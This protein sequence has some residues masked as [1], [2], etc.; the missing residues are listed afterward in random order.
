VKNKNMVALLQQTKKRHPRL[1][2]FGTLLIVFFIFYFLNLSIES[3]IFGM[4]LTSFMM[5]KL[6]AKNLAVAALASLSFSPLFLILDDEYLAEIAAMASFTLILIIFLIK[7]RVFYQNKKNKNDPRIPPR[8][9]LENINLQTL[10]LILLIGISLLF[11]QKIFLHGGQIE[12][13]DL[14]LPL[15]SQKI[16]GGLKFLWNDYESAAVNMTTNM[17]PFN[18][19]NDAV[20]YLF[21]FS[22]NIATK[23]VIAE[24]LF[25]CLFSLY[26]LLKKIFS[27]FTKNRQ[28][29]ELAS[30]A[31][32]IF[33]LFNPYSLNRIYHL[34]HWIAYL[35]L[36]L[37][38]LIFLKLLETNKAR[39]AL[40]LAILMNLISFSPHYLVYSFYALSIF[41][42][43]EIIFKFRT[44]TG[45]N[46]LRLLGRNF[47]SLLLAALLFFTLASYWLLPYLKASLI[48]DRPQAPAYMFTKRYIEA[49]EEKFQNIIS[50]LSLEPIKTE[51]RILNLL[52][53][54]ITFLL[55]LL[56]TLP[57]FSRNCRNQYTIYF[58][59]L[60]AG[61]AIFSTMPIW[62]YILYQKII[63]DL[64]Y[65]KNFG[66]LFRE[67]NRINGLLAFAY[68][69]LLSFLI[70]TRLPHFISNKTKNED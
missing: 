8:F 51:S 16:L 3:M 47:L 60:G 44:Q 61:A 4:A 63:F 23:F 67:A 17:F 24:T 21:H 28:A 43:L 50:I 12:V 5:I 42:F 14:S 38:F 36:P 55:P 57:Y 22:A 26:F 18:L 19:C 69:F 41:Y 20:F 6:P 35:T 56:L 40:A 53:Q 11:L 52:F 58:A 2:Y 9:I 15:E 31:G 70:A 13:G 10:N 65:L 59:I 66:W 25:I 37:L 34:F 7:I 45:K 64:P 1:Y 62:D 48:A 68:A 39:F 49:P 46:A 27:N 30:S 29:L 32:V 33:Y 54:I